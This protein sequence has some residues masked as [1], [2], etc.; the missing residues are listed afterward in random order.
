[1]KQRKQCKP[2][3]SNLPESLQIRF[4]VTVFIPQPNRHRKTA[5][6]LLSFEVCQI[7]GIDHKTY[8]KHEGGL[9]PVARR[10]L[11]N[12]FRIFTKQEA[13][14]LKTLWEN[15]AEY[16]SRNRHYRYHKTRNFFSLAEACQQIGISSKTFRKYEGILFPVIWRDNKAGRRLFTEKDID[17][18]KQAWEKHKR[19]NDHHC[20]PS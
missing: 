16:F 12:G 2:F 8:R 14:R 9:F 11:T 6:Y 17:Q 1:L 19:G 7:I 13:Q 15:R 5:K 4:T 18:I 20:A 10:N 3:F